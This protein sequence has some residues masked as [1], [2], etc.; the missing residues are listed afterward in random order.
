MVNQTREVTSRLFSLLFALLK[1]KAL[2]LILLMSCVSLSFSA[3]AIERPGQSLSDARI[4][5]RQQEW[6]QGEIHTLDGYWAFYW[7]QLLS[8]EMAASPENLSTQAKSFWVPGLWNDEGKAGADFPVDGFGTFY[9]R[10]LVPDVPVLYLHVPDMPSAFRLWVNGREMTANGVVARSKEDE[11]PA[12]KTRVLALPDTLGH[13][14]I[15]AQVSNHHYKEGGIWHSFKITDESGRQRLADVPVIVDAIIFAVLFSIG[16]YHLSVYY[17]RRQERASLF[18]GLFCLLLAF[19]ALAVDQRIFSGSSGFDWGMLQT[20]EHI[21]FFFCLPMF[22]AFYQALYPHDVSRRLVTVSFIA[23]TGFSLLTLFSS[24]AFFTRLALPYQIII[25]VVVFWCWHGWWGAYRN[26]REGARLLGASMAVFMLAILHD[27]LL[28]H[29]V[30]HGSPWTPLAFMAFVIAQAIILNRRYVSSLNLVEAMS[31]ELKE[32][33]TELEQLDAFKDEFLATTSHELKMPLHGIDGLA[34]GLLADARP[35][36]DES[37]KQILALISS[38]ASRLGT[39]VDD[40]LDYS[41][42]KHGKL[43]LTVTAVNLHLMAKTVL[44]TIDPLIG[45]KDIVLSLDLADG[46]EW[47]QCDVNRLQQVLFNLLGNAIK[48][49][50]E[51]YVQLKTRLKHPWVEVEVVDTGVGI[52]RDRQGDVFNPFETLGVRHQGNY[53]GTGLGLSITRK[54][55]ELQKGQLTLESEEQSGTTIRFTLPLASEAPSS[56]ASSSSVPLGTGPASDDAPAGVVGSSEGATLIPPAG[57]AHSPQDG[58]LV[59]PEGEPGRIYVVDDEETN[60]QLLKRQLQNAGFQVMTFAGGASVLERLAEG[61]PDLIIL[62]LMMPGMNGFEVCER[63]RQKHDSLRLPVVMLTARHQ[64][65]DIIQALN[66]GA[67]DYLTKPYHEKELIARISSLLGVRRYWLAS[68]ENQRLQNEIGARV[69]AEAQ[70]LQANQR[71]LAVLNQTDESV[72]L[73]DA[74]LRVIY[75]NR[76]FFVLV[77]LLE[78]RTPADDVVAGLPDGEALGMVRLQ[79]IDQLF[80]ADTVAALSDCLGQVNEEDALIQAHVLPQKSGSTPVKRAMSV[81]TIQDGGARFLAVTL[82]PPHSLREDALSIITGISSE[83]SASRAKIDSL[84]NALQCV[85]QYIRSEGQEHASE[86]GQ[87]HSPL[88]EPAVAPVV[89]QAAGS[90]SAPVE[91][92]SES[93][94]ESLSDRQALVNLLQLALDLWERYAKK[95]KIELAEESRCWRVYLDGGTMKTRTLDKYL[96]EKALPEKPRWRSV[97]RTANFVL[98]SCEMK[99]DDEGTLRGL[100][101]DVQKRFT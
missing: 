70:L 19:R 67:N 62:D 59:E 43:E 81:R 51:G 84:E 22:A 53:T 34:S 26:K 79:T 58:V 52:P 49:T 66:L 16:L 31:V 7:G 93:V 76:A 35:V 9:A 55:V 75:G 60:R 48:F 85:T 68:E 54:L 63:I 73:I 74:D 57:T 33:N 11:V 89:E 3:L 5:L 56:A 23:A 30:V 88:D 94:A 36:L 6:G 17:M 10:I 65:L 64:S 25:V 28:A 14:D 15:V 71:L 27:I 98:S 92:P 24:V 38:T 1:G 82:V 86:S 46:T 40:I 100:L 95:G 8:P 39:L 12:F 45:D 37:Q 18:F 91:Q 13:I 21:T 90:T 32:R 2:S 80:D 97:V 42:I 47:V 44:D 61:C 50:E 96:T 83:L 29:F 4:D 72:C 41:A 87:E 78:E 77:G 101:N 69:R 99:A 20:A